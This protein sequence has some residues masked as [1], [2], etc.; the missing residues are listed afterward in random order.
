MKSDGKIPVTTRLPPRLA[1][2]VKSACK[3]KRIRLE[4]F[5]EQSVIAGLEKL[6]Y[7]VPPELLEEEDEV[8]VSKAAKPGPLMKA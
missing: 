5:Y 6:G 1:V 4:T 7:Q 3:E 2:L 8:K